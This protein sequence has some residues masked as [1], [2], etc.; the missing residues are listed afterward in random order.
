MKKT[1]KLTVISNDSFP[2]EEKPTLTCKDMRAL[3]PVPKRKTIEAALEI[4]ECMKKIVD[5]YTLE[6]KAKKDREIIQALV[7]NYMGEHDTL[8]CGNKVLAT[9][10]SKSLGQLDV[11]KLKT[12]YPEVYKSCMK[13]N[14]TRYF[15]LGR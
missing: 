10:K 8:K 7:M 11:E 9:W 1:Y 14:P 15:V 3:Y 13:R 4:K 5:F 12:H 2:Q 6:K